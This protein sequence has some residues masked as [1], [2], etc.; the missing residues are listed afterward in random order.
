MTNVLRDMP[1]VEVQASEPCLVEAVGVLGE[2]IDFFDSFRD[3]L[4]RRGWTYEV[5]SQA[6]GPDGT[7]FVVAR[8][9]ARCRIEGSWDSVP[10]GDTVSVVSERFG[11]RVTCLD[12]ESGRGED[13]R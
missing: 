4:I 6:D 11:I 8:D 3:S 5:L 12:G 7:S 10:P 13:Q 2:E 9:G 1:G